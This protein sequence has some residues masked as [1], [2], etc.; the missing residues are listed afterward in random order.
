MKAKC[1]NKDVQQVNQFSEYRGSDRSDEKVR[2]HRETQSQSLKEEV[3]EKY[4]LPEQ[5]KHRRWA[6]MSNLS[7]VMKLK[8]SQN[9]QIW[10]TDLK[11]V[12]LLNKVWK[13]MN[14]TVPQSILPVNTSD[15]QQETYTVR[16]EDWEETEKMA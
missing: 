1:N 2:S 7:H 8:G 14:R 15:T 13:V 16:L 5:W 11:G 3:K 4:T 10:V 12:A 6:D 9:Y